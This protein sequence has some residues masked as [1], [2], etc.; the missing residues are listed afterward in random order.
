MGKFR[1]EK[2]NFSTYGY[3][4][5]YKVDRR[6]KLTFPLISRTKTADIDIL[7]SFKSTNILKFLRCHLN[8]RSKICCSPKTALPLKYVATTA[9]GVKIRGNYANEDV[10]MTLRRGW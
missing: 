2:L 6:S 7:T 1:L 3:M 4:Y 9:S 5:G 10:L 8:L